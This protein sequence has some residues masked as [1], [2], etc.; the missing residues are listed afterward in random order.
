MRSSV[1]TE[2][3]REI[4]QTLSSADPSLRPNELDCP[5][6]TIERG[7]KT[8]GEHAA[9]LGFTI[10][11]FGETS[12][13]ISVDGR[14]EYHFENDTTDFSGAFMTL[15]ENESLPVA[16]VIRDSD[17]DADKTIELLAEHFSLMYVLAEGDTDLPVD[18]L[19]DGVDYVIFLTSENKINI[20]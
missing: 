12:L 7:N 4:M 13:K 11:T 9:K 1:T 8:L 20:Q 2:K 16:V 6:Y 3:Y 19:S 14:F 18:V 15:N 17:G 5:S 10:Y